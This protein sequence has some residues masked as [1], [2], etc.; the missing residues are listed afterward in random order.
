MLHGRNTATPPTRAR[1]PTAPRAA[2]DSV[3]AAVLL[4]LA[5]LMPAPAGSRRPARSSSI[6]Q[7]DDLLIYNTTPGTEQTLETLARSASRAF[8]SRSTGASSPPTRCR[9]RGRRT[10]MPPIRPPTPRGRGRAMT[11]SITDAHALGIAVN[12]D[13]TSPAP[14]WA[15]QT[16]DRPDIAN[17]YSPSPVGVRRSSC[18]LSDALQRH[19][20]V[21]PPPPAAAPPPPPAPI[22]RQPAP[23]PARDQPERL[24][25]QPVAAAPAD[26]AAAE[27][28]RSR[29]S[30]AGRS[31]TS[32]TRRAG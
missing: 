31:G 18:R 22:Q 17:T 32:P 30:A 28:R 10:S 21:P 16:P 29:G 9:R 26:A 15:T 6:F 27:P 12:L 1:N 11:R 13:I 20:R 14:L 7:D 2:H 4:A 25:Q 5:L 23:G 8:G 19:L 24:G 3:L